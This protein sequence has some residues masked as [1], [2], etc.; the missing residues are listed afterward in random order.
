MTRKA[1]P[2]LGGTSGFGDGEREEAGPLPRFL[3]LGW[4]HTSQHL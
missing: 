3:A 2:V 4:Q 1:E